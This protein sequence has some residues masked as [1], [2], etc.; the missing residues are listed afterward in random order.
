M[1]MDIFDDDIR[2]GNGDP[3]FKVN[4]D[5]ARKYT[6]NKKREELRKRKDTHRLRIVI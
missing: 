5:Y 1:A 6:H 2:E 4:E 3:D